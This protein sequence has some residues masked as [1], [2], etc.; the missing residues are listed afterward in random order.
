MFFCHVVCRMLNCNYNGIIASGMLS[1]FKLYINS[2]S[3]GRVEDDS[4]KIV[5]LYY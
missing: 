1:P 2:T 3:K 5:A 4:R